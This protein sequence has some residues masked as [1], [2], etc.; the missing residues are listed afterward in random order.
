MKTKTKDKAKTKRPTKL[1]LS[2][3]RWTRRK[4]VME[5]PTVTA[6]PPTAELT[7]EQIDVL[8]ARQDKKNEII[9][10]ITREVDASKLMIYIKAPILAN[11]LRKFT[12]GNALE[13]DI[14]PIYREIL[15]PIYKDALIGAAS[16]RVTPHRFVTRPSIAK[17]T[18]NFMPKPD[19]DWG[20]KPSTILLANPDALEAGFTL[21]YKVEDKPV[22]PEHIRQWGESFFRGCNDIIANARPFKMAWVMTED[23]AKK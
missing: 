18:K 9:L 12:P 15:Q 20:D 8:K 5:N 3:K 1:K 11:V 22:P 17:I 10:E 16:G 4:I 6:N 19:F 2:T 14:S 21:I 7:E 13:G 23:T